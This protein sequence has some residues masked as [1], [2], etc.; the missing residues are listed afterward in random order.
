MKDELDGIFDGLT[1][2][3]FMRSPRGDLT[4][5]HSQPETFEEFCHRHTNMLQM[6][7]TAS[8]GEFSGMAILAQ[9]G[10]KPTLE[11]LFL[12]QEEESVGNFVNRLTAEVKEMGA[13]TL[14]YV[15]C[16]QVKVQYLTPDEV[17]ESDLAVDRMDNGEE[18]LMWYCEYDGT[19]RIGAMFIDD[20]GAGITRTV[21]TSQHASIL[22]RILGSSS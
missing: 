1:I 3:D 21:E 4:L 11:R 15:M 6:I 19:R 14:F 9:L 5:R 2:E 7:F 20:H 16:T 13:N 8:E 10:A 22:E 12:P 17:S 18:A